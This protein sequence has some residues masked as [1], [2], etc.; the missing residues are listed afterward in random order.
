ME[1]VSFSVSNY[2]SIT[3]AY[4]LPIRQST[5]LIGPNNEGKSNVLRAL[6]TALEVLQALSGRRILAGRLRSFRVDSRDTYYW[7]HDFPISLQEKR[8]EGESVFDLEFRLT[9]SEIEEFAAEVGSSLNGTLPIQLTL[10]QREPGFRVVKKGP[11]GPALSKKAEKIANFVA[12]RINI[13]YIP[14][15]R[16]AEAAQE[17]V[18]RMVERQLSAIE[19]D[20]A[21]KAA[22]AAVAKL[23]QPLLDRLSDGI[24][25]T[26]REFLPNVKQ[27]RVG[28]PPE[29][30]YRALRRACEIVVD[31]GTPTHLARKGD[32]VQSLAALSLMRQASG[33]SLAGKQLILAIEEP[34][35][36]L[37]PNAIHQL[38]AVLAEI[39]RTNQV[40][41]TT[42]CPLFVD[43]TT[44]KSNIIVHRSKAVAARSVRE[45]RDV[46]GVRASDN[47]RHAELILVVEGEED[48]RAVRA[49]LTHYSKAL[50][51]ALA[52]GALGIESL[53][54]GSNLSFKLSQVREA[55]CVAHA[56]LDDDTAGRTA[57]EKAT[58]DG[59]F[60]IADANLTTCVGR[61]EAEI[62]DLYDEGLYSTM[63]QHRY[64]VSTQSPKFKGTA[65]WSDRL[66]EAFKH[67]GKP[68]SEQIEARVKTEVAELVESNAATALNGHQKS[69]FD[70]LVAALE[71]KLTT[72]AAGKK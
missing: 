65:K 10:G 43:R 64:G 71:A 23:Q 35:S 20:P 70:A 56:F 55:L 63:L 21:Y 52:Q 15:V 42:H 2:R 17:I 28:I 41:M 9:Q 26:L 4:K 25:D 62:E 60:T 50:A 31:D 57:V 44:I 37:H 72:I 54:G 1:L 11:G 59:L 40:I 69:C 53:Q 39:A 47:L 36:H 13:N 68:W 14:A 12:K 3:K 61:K 49:L 32:G 18:T 51:S 38:K 45:I 30:R 19:E 33:D 22:L 48:R 66:R 7:P 46:L 6:V 27:V 34:E 58:Q 29:A 8:P 16:T 24:R 67:Q 5:I